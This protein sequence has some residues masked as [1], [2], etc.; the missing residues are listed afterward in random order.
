MTESKLNKV[1]VSALEDVKGIDILSI[2]VT[3][4]TSIVDA[5]V[6]ATGTSTRQLKGLMRNLVDETK[7]AGFRPIGVEG[8]DSGD[9]I[10]VDFG[11][12]AVHIMLPETRE[13]YD[14]ER[15]WTERPDSRQSD[16]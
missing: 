9:W 6:I 13:F 16:L 11:E 2:D 14:L 1:I 15:L 4:L 5:M 8:E 10:L 3:G 7:N 12:I